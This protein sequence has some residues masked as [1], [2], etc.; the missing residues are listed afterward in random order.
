MKRRNYGRIVNMSSVSGPLVTFANGGA[1]GF[2]KAAMVGL[3]RSLAFELGPFGM[4]ANAVAPGWIANGK[5]SKRLM[6]G[7]EHTPVGPP[8]RPD[9]VGSLV[10]Y[11]ASEEASYLTGQMIVVDGGNTIQEYNGDD[12][13]IS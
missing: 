9:E 4:T 11:L 3:T 10:V 5:A 7:G 8:G 6:L 2:A 12:V 1:Y 13:A